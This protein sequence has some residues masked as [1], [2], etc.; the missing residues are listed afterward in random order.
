M[1]SKVTN[2]LICLLKPYLSLAMSFS[3]FP[4]ASKVVS[5]SDSIDHSVLPQVV[6]DGID[7]G[8]LFSIP[9]Q[10]SSPQDHNSSAFDNHDQP[11]SCSPSPAS[12]DSHNSD[13]SSSPSPTSSDSHNS[14]KPPSLSQ[15]PLPPR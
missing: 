6:Y 8:S 13:K 4:Y 7:H 5:K 9:S 3:I 10:S 15:S 11:S 1:V 12:S 14:D 2:Y